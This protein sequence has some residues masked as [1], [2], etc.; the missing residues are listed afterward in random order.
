MSLKVGDLYV[1]LG[2]RLNVSQFQRSAEQLVQ[3]AEKTARKAS[4]A[5]RDIGDIGKV[6]MP[7][8]AAFSAGIA[9]AVKDAENFS[10]A[11]GQAVD[12]SKHAFN[13]LAMEVSDLVLPAFKE[14]TKAV[15][16]VVGWLQS[17]TPEQRASVAHWL[18]MG[19]AV[20]AAVVAFGK[21]ST[22]AATLVKFFP[23]LAGVVVS[24]GPPLVAIVALAGVIIAAFAYVY[25]TLRPY[26]SAIAEVASE[27][28]QKMKDTFWAAVD[29]IARGLSWL[30][31]KLHLSFSADAIAGG[32]SKLFDSG[33]RLGNAIADGVKSGLKEIGQDTGVTGLI[34]KAKGILSGKG[35][36]YQRKDYEY[37]VGGRF[38]DEHYD[39]GAEAMETLRKQGYGDGSVH[40]LSGDMAAIT[41]AREKKE[42]EERFQIEAK[43]TEA[44]A[45]AMKEASD[46]FQKKIKGAFGRASELF[47]SIEQ[48]MTM[49]GPMGALVGGLVDVLSKS[50]EFETLVNM[51][52]TIMGRVSEAF[53]ALLQGLEPLMGAVS[54]VV[55]Q[56][57]KLLVPV[58]KSLANAGQFL[59]PLLELV[60]NL[61]GAIAPVVNMLVGVFQILQLPMQLLTLA[62][63]A[64][65]PILKIAAE[66]IGYVVLGLGYAWNAIVDAMQWVL[67][68]LSNLPFLGDLADTARSMDGW[69]VNIDAISDGLGKLNDSTWDSAS[70]QAA[71]SGA[72][73]GLASALGDTTQVLNA[74]QGFKVSLAEWQA[75]GGFPNPE[76]PNGSSGG[77]SITA[78]RSGGHPSGGGSP[79]LYLPGTGASTSPGGVFTGPNI[80]GGVV[81][82]VNGAQD[83][84]TVAAQVQQHLTLA[85]RARSGVSSPTAPRYAY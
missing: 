32:I 18:E 45:E 10:N 13:T 63:K 61:L 79:T 50:K 84:K 6:A 51:I 60:T 70:A 4:R 78:P 9:L 62:I 49:G 26:F 31:Q 37:K 77:G 36:K 52:N 19:A 15:E 46:D 1:S 64:L 40:N 54:D 21:I 56:V 55:D 75:A 35:G 2:A 16:N 7:F 41:Q 29:A 11:A 83:P 27:A 24:I 3:E 30:A 59:A 74:P 28:W 73:L 58:F 76:A 69:K 23:A 47:A 14:M 68:A 38:A 17:L 22:M 44:L 81:I 65:Y 72:A 48:G 8:A 53:G 33:K 82:N 12:Q 34:D 42:M 20:A 66:A 85:N 39:P 80:N 57:L 25:H 71:A 43:H 67:D 5:L